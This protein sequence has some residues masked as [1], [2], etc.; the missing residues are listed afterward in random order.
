MT[1]D[2]LPNGDHVVRYAKPTS[3]RTDGRVD[4]SAFCLRADRPE[5]TLLSANWLECF[6]DRTKHEQLKEVRRLS[7]LT[8]RRRGR[9]AELNV[10]ATRQHVHRERESLRFIHAPLP[11]DGKFEPD[12]SHSGLAGLPPGDSPDAALIGDM[13]AECI[14]DLYAVEDT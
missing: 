1:G 10:G 3:V 5:E 7:R 9:L 14:T 12:P 6:R 2:D 13:I 11:A 4:G 8:M